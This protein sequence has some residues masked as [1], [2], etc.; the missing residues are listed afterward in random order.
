MSSKKQHESTALWGDALPQIQ[1]TPIE[2]TRTVSM[3]HI[4][5]VVPS[6]RP[7]VPDG[8]LSA[9]SDAKWYEFERD[10]GECFA[11][12]GC[13]L[14]RAMKPGEE[15]ALEDAEYKREIWLYG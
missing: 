7:E 14:A 8:L 5:I 11:L 13:D 2:I 3:T 15:K 9:F 6:W 1:Q 12:F 4:E 10:G